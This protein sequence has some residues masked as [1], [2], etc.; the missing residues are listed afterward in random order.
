MDYAAEPSAHSIKWRIIKLLKF[1][2][3]H[4][5]LCLWM[6]SNFAFAQTSQQSLAQNAIDKLD[7]DLRYLVGQY[8]KYGDFAVAVVDSK[9]VR[10]SINAKTAYPL[11]SVF[12]LP[13]LLAI[14]K[15]QEDGGFPAPD[16]VLTVDLSDQCIGS[17][18]LMG[19]GVG[20]RVSVDEA[21]R[22]MM[23]ISD[24][25]ATDLLFR[26]Y[27]EGKL[28]KQLAQ[29]GFPSSQII[30]T[31]R[32][33][34]LLSLGVVPG[35]GTTSPAQRVKLWKALSREQKLKTA[36]EIESS[37]SQMS[38]AQ[39]QQIEDA[40]L[41]TQSASE[42]RL[43]AAQL[44]NK[45][46]AEDLAKMLVALDQGKLM[47]A[48]SRSRALNIL[49]GQKY[50]SRLPSKL[51]PS[52]KIY[53]KTGTLAGVRNDAGLLFFPGRNDGVAVVFLSQNVTS[54]AR[55]DSLAAQVAKLVEQAY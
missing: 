28:D 40:S 53:H 52:T 45:M 1:S 25:T 54:E 8:A 48:A 22:L 20:T 10:A 32:Q 14:L 5:L 9:G 2:P 49:A 51:S 42:D 18:S 39:F 43:L 41:G 4:C 6:T 44:D 13:L 55:A 38:L 17:G 47:S 26:K 34:W 24:N 30:L 50:H 27:G 16:S 33:A 36:Q 37:K 15:S 35:W 11:A 23:S 12:K 31:N 46:S 21:S 19:R 29:W 3:L 7:N